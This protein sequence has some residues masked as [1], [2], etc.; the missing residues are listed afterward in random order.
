MSSEKKPRI[1]KQ[2][3]KQKFKAK[4]EFTI[5]VEFEGEAYTKEDFEN[6]IPSEVSLKDYNEWDSEQDSVIELTSE[7]CYEHSEWD[8]YKKTYTHERSIEKIAECVPTEDIDENGN[9]F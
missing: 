3:G 6:M 7:K 1:D 9:D 2:I 8:H 4:R 5:C